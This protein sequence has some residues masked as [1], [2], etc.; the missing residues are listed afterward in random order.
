MSARMRAIEQ[1]HKSLECARNQA[2]PELTG[3]T[4]NPDG[5]A[6]F[7][8]NRTT[9]NQRQGNGV[10]L[11]LAR[12]KLTRSK[13][14]C[15]GHLSEGAESTNGNEA[16]HRIVVRHASYAHAGMTRL[17]F[18]I[19]LC[20]TILIAITAQAALIE[21]DPET[22]PAIADG[23]CSLIEAI[24]NANTDSAMN[25]DC[26]M[27]NGTDLLRLSLEF[28]Y[29]FD[30]A[31]GSTDNALPVI[32]DDVIVQ[33][34]NATISRDNFST[35][36]FRLLEFNAGT[37]SMSNLNLSGGISDFPMSGG[38]A[39]LATDSNLTLSDIRITG[40]T[41]E[42]L[43]AFG[44]ALRL[45]DSI[46]EITD[47][48]LQVNRTSSSS[49]ET[50]GGA[51]AQFNGSLTI[52]RSALLNNDANDCGN[53]RGGGSNTAGTGGALRIEATGLP[54][55]FAIFNDSTIASNQGR[56]GGG[57]H[58]VAIAD[59]GV[60]GEDVLVQLVRSTL[61]QN[62]ANACTGSALGDGMHVQEA[63]GGSGTVTYGSSII[64]GNGRLVNNIVVGVD[65]SANFPSQTY[66]SFD[67]NVLDAQDNC[68]AR[69]DTFSD[70]YR[71]IVDPIRVDNHYLPLR[72]GPAVDFMEANFNCN[73]MLPDA[74][75]NPRAG[76]PG[77][78]G[79]ICD[80]G[81]IELQYP[82][83]DFTLQTTLAGTGSG[84]L[85]SNPGGI[86]CPGVCSADYPVGSLVSLT[87]SPA[88]GSVFAGWNGDCS[89]MGACQVT[90]DQMRNV[91]ATFDLE[92]VTLTILLDTPGGAAG[93]VTSNP[94]GINCPGDCQQDF[95]PGTN[96]TLTATPEPGSEFNLWGGV[97]AA[98]GGPVCNATLTMN[99]GA[100]AQFVLV[101][102]DP[103]LSITVTGPGSITD[104]T[105]AINCP[106]TCSASYPSNT[107]ITLTPTPDVDASFQNFT[108]AC[109]GQNCMLQL[110]DDQQVGGVFLP[111]GGVFNDG[112]E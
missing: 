69:F 48:L 53:S 14:I 33:G 9:P 34:R 60:V 20:S 3:S 44:G 25:P 41:A 68:I 75:G 29:E 112:F 59:T 39:I 64:H 109:S 110:A 108:S 22:N 78:G 85:S 42:G 6:S 105:G 102:N 93:S 45:D 72:N 77:M 4:S 1:G 82:V 31:Y 23:Q 63:N 27:G 101:E 38:G 40:N 88:G 17:L 83:D 61:V 47:A 43:F 73:T 16:E 24:E 62:D 76:G 19:I 46:V 71:N 104:N 103:V 5:L 18:W 54:G 58:L 7:Q 12:R 86:N 106:G 92:P 80:A 51:I 21:V 97:C 28:K 67:G 35:E 52:N 15:S 30:S 50:G 37:H 49:A 100:T 11:L 111:A 13:R 36:A 55:A 81:A 74:V 65:C 87:P 94:A 91:T 2:K 32:V 96:I 66:M 56:V 57:I 84:S 10:R 89:G 70:D 98:S 107:S 26:P 95:P 99:G 90:M 79:G 8:G